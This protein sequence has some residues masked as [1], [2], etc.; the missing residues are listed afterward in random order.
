[1]LAARKPGVTC[2]AAETH[3]L[4]AMFERR[5]DRVQH[6]GEP[7]GVSIQLW[8]YPAVFWLATIGV[9]LLAGAPDVLS[10]IPALPG[11]A[12]VDA[13]AWVAL[14]FAVVL[15]FGWV[16]RRPVQLR[17]HPTAAHVSGWVGVYFPVRSDVAL[18][19]PVTVSRRKVGL[20]TELTLTG[21]TGATANLKSVRCS[22]SELKSI[23]EAL[24]RVHLLAKRG[25]VE[26]VPEQLR[27]LLHAQSASAKSKHGQSE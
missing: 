3:T 20:M 14:L 21:S 12:G 17:I 23:E 18:K 16:V 27:E 4:G 10:P 7:D 22:E 5:D 8:Q 19:Q 1:M 6:S 2:T 13:L 24:T 11:G 9:P 25:H 26:D 15:A